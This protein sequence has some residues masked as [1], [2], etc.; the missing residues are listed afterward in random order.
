[1]PCSPTGPTAFDL[2]PL[3]QM[4]IATMILAAVPL[5]PAFRAICRACGIVSV[6]IYYPVFC[7]APVSISAPSILPG[8]LLRAAIMKK[9]PKSKIMNFLITIPTPLHHILHI[10]HRV[11]HVDWQDACCPER[12]HTRD[13]AGCQAQPAGKACAPG[14]FYQVCCSS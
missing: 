12:C 6:A 5:K 4:A 13:R 3:S 7:N 11:L 8:L 2:S 14:D 10:P 9:S 1:M